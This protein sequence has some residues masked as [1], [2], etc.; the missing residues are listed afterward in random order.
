MYPY[1]RL[2]R[3]HWFLGPREVDELATVGEMFARLPMFTNFEPATEQG[4][5]GTLIPTWG[6]RVTSSESS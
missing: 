2:A 6:L 3:V 4:Q 5:K 1:V